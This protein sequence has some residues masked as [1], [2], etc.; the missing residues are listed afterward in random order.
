MARIN[1][2]ID[3][4]ELNIDGPLKLEPLAGVPNFSP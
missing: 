2:V 3:H 1:R 4:I